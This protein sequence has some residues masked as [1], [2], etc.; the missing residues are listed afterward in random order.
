MRKF[1][2]EDDGVAGIGQQGAQPGAGRGTR[3]VFHGKNSGQ[4]TVDGH[5]D[6]L[7]HTRAPS[8]ICTPMLR[9]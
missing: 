1:R 3:L 2:G 9:A 8:D 5:L 6:G 7:P 4:L